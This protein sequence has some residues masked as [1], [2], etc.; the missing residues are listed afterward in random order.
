M[1]VIACRTCC[2]ALQYESISDLPDFPFCSEKCK[3]LDLGEWFEG[4]RRIETDVPATESDHIPTS[5]Q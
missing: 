5:D 4:N 2:K 3:L 1:P